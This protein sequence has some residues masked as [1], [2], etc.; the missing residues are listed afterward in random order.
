MATEATG[1]QLQPMSLVEEL[2]EVGVELVTRSEQQGLV[3]AELAVT[4]DSMGAAEEEAE[5]VL[6]AAT[7]GPVETVDKAS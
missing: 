3:T 5:D 7:Q 6:T 1:I 4:A 2:V